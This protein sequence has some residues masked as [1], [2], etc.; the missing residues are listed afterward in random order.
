M[1]SAQR[2]ALASALLSADALFAVA[3]TYAETPDFGVL[4]VRWVFV[5]RVVSK[6][7]ILSGTTANLNHPAAAVAVVERKNKLI[8]PQ[9]RQS[10]LP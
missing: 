7:I 5:W 6:H 4:T 3:G 9:I 2:Q 10:K 8:E 1:K